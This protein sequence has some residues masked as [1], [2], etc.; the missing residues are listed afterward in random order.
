MLDEEWR[1]WPHWPFIVGLGKIVHGPALLC[2]GPGVG[3]GVRCVF[4]YPE[5]LIVSFSVRGVGDAVR[6]IGYA[7]PTAGTPEVDPDDPGLPLS[8]VRLAFTVDRRHVGL[9]GTPRG[10]I[11]SGAMTGDRDPDPVPIYERDLDAWVA[12]LPRDGRLQVQAGWPEVGLPL[13]TTILT[14][15]GLDEVQ[16]PDRAHGAVQALR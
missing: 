6:L 5:G 7:S 8:E 12:P 10:R 4:A 11:F 14:L 1:P 13:S 2:A 16:D 15:H 3:M 9:T